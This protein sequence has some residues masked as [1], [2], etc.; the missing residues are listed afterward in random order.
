MPRPRFRI[1]C[2]LCRKPIPQAKDVYALDEEWQR[3]F[4]DMIGTLACPKCAEHNQWR[5]R[6]PGGTFANG[7]RRPASQTEDREHDS[8]DHMRGH[9]THAAMV[10]SHPWS[11]LLQ[12]LRT[13]CA[14]RCGVQASAG[15]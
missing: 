1:V 13:I 2:C 14:T 9:G 11:G 4:P 15:R 5:C 12:G 6:R 10:I 7:H 3:R 8:W